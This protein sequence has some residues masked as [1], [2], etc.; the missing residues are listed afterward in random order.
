MGKNIKEL[1]KI[2]FVEVGEWML[3]GDNIDFN[4]VAD[5]SVEILYS[6]VKIKNE[7][8]EVI[9]IGKTIRTI[10]NRLNGYKKPSISQ[11]TNIRLNKK[12]YELLTNNNSVKIYFFNCNDKLT[13]KNYQINLSAGLE[14][15]LIKMFNP[16]FNL[17]GNKKIVEEVEL[18][19]KNIQLSSLKSEMDKDYKCK[20][21]F[22]LTKTATVSHLRGKINLG[23]VLINFL[24]NFG[25]I[26]N[27][28]IG[29]IVFQA[30][31]I[32]A[33]QGGYNPM[34]NSVTIG[35]WLVENNINVGNVFFIKICNN[36]SFHFYLNEV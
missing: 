9:Y 11:N 22:N 8:K 17:H 3:N 33:N 10:S 30:N 27:I 15:I 13:Y 32:N 6:F 20:N 16:E 18:D 14:D 21:S 29:E 31:F 1:E 19:D 25:E 7:K 4:I 24:P 36:N 28:Y 34:I 2:G 12:I 35:N 23:E 26:V 5:N